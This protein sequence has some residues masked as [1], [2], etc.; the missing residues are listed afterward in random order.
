M[1][2]LNVVFE[3]KEYEELTKMKGKKAWREFILQLAKV[4]KT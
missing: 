2:T 3:D 1:K 4:K